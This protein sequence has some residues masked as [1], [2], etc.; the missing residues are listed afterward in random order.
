MTR[1]VRIVK[2][3][4]ALALLAAV[5]IVI[6]WALWHF[7]GWP[8]PHHAPSASQISRALNR[9]GIPDQTLVDALAVVVWITWATLVVSIAVEIAAALKGRHASRLP[10]AGIFQPVTGRL[11]AT[12]I[13]ACLS[14]APRPAHPSSPGSSGHNPSAGTA[15]RPVAAFVLKGRS[16]PMPQS[17]L[18]QHQRRLPRHRPPPTPPLQARRR[19]SR[20]CTSSS[21]ATPSGASPNT[22]SAIPC[23]GQRSTNSTRTDPNPAGSPSPTPTGSTRAGRCSCRPLPPHLAQR[24]LRH[25]QPRQHRPHRHQ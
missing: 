23:A 3:L 19:G 1:P 7:V 11:V 17:P 15:P 20:P 5:V 2:G 6:P 22:N 13:V 9:Q 16:L 10:L 4:A 14:L 21:A 12:V 8:L 25:Q 24:P 18:R